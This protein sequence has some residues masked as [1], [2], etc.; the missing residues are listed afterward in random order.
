M[1]S[2][3]H[4]VCHALSHMHKYHMTPGNCTQLIHVQYL[5]EVS[6][7]LTYLQIL[8]NTEDTEEITLCYNVK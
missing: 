8:K 2:L 6:T 1:Q 7:P 5:T 3:T 4:I